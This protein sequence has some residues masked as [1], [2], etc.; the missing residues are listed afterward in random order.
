[1]EDPRAQE[2]TL[3]TAPGWRV[4]SG[5]HEVGG[6]SLDHRVEQLEDDLNPPLTY[7][8]NSPSLDPGS[9]RRAAFPSMVLAPASR[10][11]PPVE[12]RASKGQG[13]DTS[14]SSQNRLR[15]TDGGGGRWTIKASSINV[16]RM[17]GAGLRAALIND[18]GANRWNKTSPGGMR[19]QTGS[20]RLSQC[21]CLRFAG[22]NPGH[23]SLAL[24]KPLKA[25][26]AAATPV[27]STGKPTKA[28]TMSKVTQQGDELGSFNKEVL[29]LLLLYVKQTATNQ[30]SFPLPS[31]GV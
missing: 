24:G 16:L 11:F 14:L 31:G 13:A 19:D 29:S 22:E 20:G 28:K 5:A 26:A 12:I 17:A 23:M 1:M 6:M 15:S 2:N 27:E 8:L 9:L 4:H 3:H 30:S 21:L 7:H 18:R 25:K 10:L